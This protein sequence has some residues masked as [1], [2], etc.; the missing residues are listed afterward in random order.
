MLKQGDK[1]PEFSLPDQEGEMHSLSDYK[2]RRVLLYFYP[3]DDTPGCTTEAC[4][5][6]DS[7][8]EM[9]KRG[10]TI[11]GV[12]AD[13]VKSHRTFAD[14]YK[15]PFPILADEDRKVINA[16]GVWQKKKFMGREYMG[17]V[18]TS[19]LIDEKGRIE[20]VYAD[21]KAAKHAEEVKA[22]V[23]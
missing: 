16:Y 4:N 23:K 5:F 17:I 9:E 12:S 21:V 10:L 1:A 6:R 13:T 11:L 14:K 2:G 18:R 15:L 22:D 20:K 3:K 8:E 7:Y 19:F